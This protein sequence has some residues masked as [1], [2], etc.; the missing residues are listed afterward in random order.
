MS[1]FLKQ[2]HQ[3]NLYYFN[4]PHDSSK[5]DY[6]NDW[7]PVRNLCGRPPVGT[8]RARA[9]L[10]RQTSLRPQTSCSQGARVWPSLNCGLCYCVRPPFSG[11]DG[12]IQQIQ[13]NY[14]YYTI[15][16][17]SVLLCM[18]RFHCSCLTSSLH[19]LQF[20]ENT[21][22]CYWNIVSKDSQQNQYSNYLRN[23]KNLSIK[24][25]S[26][27]P[28]SLNTSVAKK[29]KKQQRNK[30][31]LDHDCLHSG[32]NQKIIK[33]HKTSLENLSLVFK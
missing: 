4:W 8:G 13:K 7:R 31:K 17:L 20:T 9:G 1:L 16:N 30:Q 29:N 27:P 25:L 32:T 6:L 22:F 24:L 28:V 12:T 21:T 23:T 15:K 19:R 33:A 18:K 3:L 10:R 14:Y 11:C 5:G 2:I 26:L